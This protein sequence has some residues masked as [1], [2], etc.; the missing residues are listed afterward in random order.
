MRYLLDTNVV[1]EVSK[2]RPSGKVLNFIQANE[3]QCVVP[4]TVVA[5]RYYGAQIAPPDQRAALLRAV[6]DFRNEFADRILPFD[7]EAAE[8][9]GG[10]V[11]RPTLKNKPRS[12]PDTQIAAIAL[13]HNLIVVTR[14]TK[15]FPEVETL[16]PFQD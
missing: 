9:W 2:K 15:D 16:N 8:T 12:Y 7:A 14:N 13:T 4:A 11:S 10:Y 1:S 6:H 5:E 3:A